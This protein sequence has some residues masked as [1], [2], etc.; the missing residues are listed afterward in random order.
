M[1]LYGPVRAFNQTSTRHPNTIYSEI[2]FS[3]KL[4]DWKRSDFGRKL[5]RNHRIE[6]EL[7]E[8]FL[9]IY[10]ELK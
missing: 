5:I 4:S 7:N 2:A 10:I 6:R 3:F 8:H 9:K 1:G